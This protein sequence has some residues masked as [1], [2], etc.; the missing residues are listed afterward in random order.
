MGL[1]TK[2]A[3]LDKYYE[4]LESGKA[5][6]IKPSHVEKVIKKLKAKEELLQTELKDADK[7]SKKDRLKRK[8]KT[9]REQ[10]KRAEWLLDEIRDAK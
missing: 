7:S 5:Q 8:I 10:I 1:S 9:A 4:R 6:K 2:I 3:K